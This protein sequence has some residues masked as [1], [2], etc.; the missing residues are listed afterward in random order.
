M[1]QPHISRYS[2]SAAAAVDLDFPQAVSVPDM[3]AAEVV[4]FQE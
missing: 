3:T 2:E 4:E 1:D